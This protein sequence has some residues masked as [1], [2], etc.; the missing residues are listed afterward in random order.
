MAGARQRA[1]RLEA[2]GVGA[3]AVADAGA[4]LGAE[5]QRDRRGRRAQVRDPGQVGVVEVE[6]VAGRRQ[7]DDVVAG[8]PRR[9]RRR[10]VRAPGCARQPVQERDCVCLRGQLDSQARSSSPC[11]SSA[12]RAR[13]GSAGARRR[14]AAAG[15][16]AARRRRSATGSIPSSLGQRER[17]VDLVDRPGRDA[18]LAQHARPS[19]PAGSRRAGRSPAP[20]PARR[21]ARPAPRWWRSAR[22]RA[23]RAGPSASHRRANMRSLPTATA[24]GAV[25]GLVGLVGDDARVAVAAPAGRTPPATHA[26]PWLSRQVERGVHQRDLDVAPAA[27]ARALDAARPGCRWRR[28]ARTPGRRPP[29]RPSAARPSGSPVTAISPPIA[30]SRKS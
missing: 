20:R 24:S 17:L 19:A 13:G 8:R 16:S 26:V 12:R 11:S 10:L 2:G 18:R 6:H 4:A 28:A 5:H 27:G 7:R 1:H 23:A 15:G 30:C 9:A 14:R 22:R 21:R 25:G 29:C 3:S